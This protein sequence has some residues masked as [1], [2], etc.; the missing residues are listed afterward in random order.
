MYGIIQNFLLHNVLTLQIKEILEE[1]L[2]ELEAFILSDNLIPE[3]GLITASSIILIISLINSNPTQ[4]FNYI[5]NK[6]FISYSKKNTNFYENSAQNLQKYIKDFNSFNVLKD[7][8]NFEDESQLFLIPEFQPCY[9]NFILIH[10]I[11][12]MKPSWLYISFNISELKNECI[13][14]E[15]KLFHF[16]NKSLLIKLWPFIQKHCTT[17]SSY[18]HQTIQV[19]HLWLELFHLFINKKLE[20]WEVQVKTDKLEQP[21]DELSANDS[22]KNVRN[23]EKNA[24]CKTNK[25]LNSDNCDL[26]ERIT[27]N[28]VLCA[29]VHFKSLFSVDENDFGEILQVLNFV[30]ENQN[31]G[32]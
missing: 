31:K 21:D 2:K 20:S 11:L 17:S 25:I 6:S 7:N 16:L 9:S 28:C 12:N 29:N 3:V 18:S 13:P 19:L 14:N 23:L 30:F 27:H 8:I 4:W 10:G 15:I 5:L 32:M 26:S 22:F 1:I 24:N